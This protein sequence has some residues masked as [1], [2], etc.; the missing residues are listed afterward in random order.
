MVVVW[1]W[2]VENKTKTKGTKNNN[3]T[4]FKKPKQNVDSFIAFCS[5]MVPPHPGRERPAAQIPITTTFP[6]NYFH[7]HY[8]QKGETQFVCD[9]LCVFVHFVPFRRLFRYGPRDL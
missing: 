9:D 7:F 1:K 5:F 4:R 2:V 8:P 6:T 3:N